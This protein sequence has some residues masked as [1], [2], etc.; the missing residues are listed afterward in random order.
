MALSDKQLA[1]IAKATTSAQGIVT[2]S[3]EKT[4]SPRQAI[5]A[6]CLTCTGFNREEITE[7]PVTLC[8]LHAYRAYQGGV[9]DSEMPANAS[10][11]AEGS[12]FFD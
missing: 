3:F 6:M 7:C 11:L 5:K 8:P 10:N 9:E 1:Y 2:R 4:A 12:I